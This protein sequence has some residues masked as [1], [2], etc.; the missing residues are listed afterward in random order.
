MSTTAS[1]AVSVTA[2]STAPTGTGRARRAIVSAILAIGAVTV[3]VLVLWQPWGERDH[4]GYAE[5]APHRDAAWL[6]GIA[7]GLAFAAIGV[8]LGLAVCLLAPVRGAVWANVGAVLTGIGGVA[9]CAG[10]ASFGSFAW[11]ATE[12]SAIPAEAGSTLMTYAVDHPGHLLGLQMLGFALSTIGSLV[13]MV[14]LWRTRSVPRWLPIAYLV[15]TVALFAVD[16]I[17]LNV[18]QAVQTLSLLVV[19]YAVLRVD[20][21]AAI[22]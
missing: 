14:A 11:Y 6:G 2:A 4:L 15:L 5:I 8:A 10:I 13:L 7:D 12:T 9:F 21:P 19:A 3:A 20:R 22:G 17:V 1:P 16:G 18:V